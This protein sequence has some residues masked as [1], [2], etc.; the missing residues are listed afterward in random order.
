M[1]AKSQAQAKLMRAV[2]HNPAFA[3]KVGIPPKVGKE[4]SKTVVNAPKRV[5]KRTQKRG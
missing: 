1:P 2:A 3:K 5:Q 4:F